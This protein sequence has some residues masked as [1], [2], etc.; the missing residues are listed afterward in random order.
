MKVLFLDFDGVLN[1]RQ[2]VHYHNR[3]WKRRS[4]L[5][6]RIMDLVHSAEHRVWKLLPHRW[7][8]R[9]RLT[10]FAL[11]YLC[12]HCDFCPIACSNVQYL[13]DKFPDLS[14]VVSSTWRSRGLMYV[15]AVLDRNGVDPK[16][17][18][19]VTPT[20]GEDLDGKAPTQLIGGQSYPATV[21]GHQIQAWL[22]AHR[23]VGQFVIVDDDSDM[24]HLIGYLVKTDGGEGFMWPKVRQ[25]MTM[26][27]ACQSCESIDGTHPQ[28]CRVAGKPAS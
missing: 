11:W 14:I 5:V 24:A 16:R 6:A 3:K 27:G 12:D 18:V 10:R 23:E 26:L 9:D 8:L 20:F 7:R 28:W 21:R 15:R 13:L 2:E 1:S 22:N 19:G 17:V 4:N 25:A